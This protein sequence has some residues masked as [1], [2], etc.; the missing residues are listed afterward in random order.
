MLTVGRLHWKKGYEYALKALS[1]LKNKQINF[2]E[3]DEVKT[4]DLLAQID[5]REY[6]LE[7][8][9]LEAE[10]NAA[11][12]VFKKAIEGFFRTAILTSCRIYKST[13]MSKCMVTKIYIRIGTGLLF[14]IFTNSIK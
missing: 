2:E 8:E 5:S 14:E 4:G 9:E 7:V 3:G 13:K 10:L 12:E 11:K 1:L 6:E